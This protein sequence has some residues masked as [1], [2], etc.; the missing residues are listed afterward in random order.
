MQA[1][2]QPFSEEICRGLW[3]SLLLV[4]LLEPLIVKGE[5]N[6]SKGSSGVTNNALPN[7]VIGSCQATNEFMNNIASEY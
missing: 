5:R 7:S 3:V 2:S 4:D 1:A 6:L